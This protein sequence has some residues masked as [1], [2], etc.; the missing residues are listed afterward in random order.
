MVPQFVSSSVY[1]VL[2]GCF[3]WPVWRKLKIRE[4]GRQNIPKRGA[5]IFAAN[6]VKDV[7]S[8]IL[9]GAARRLVHFMAKKTLFDGGKKLSLKFIKILV[10]L[11]GQI[12]VKAGDKLVVKAAFEMA[13]A[14]LKRGGAVGMHVEGT[15][16]LDGKL[17]APKLGFTK[18]AYETRVPVVPVALR[19]DG[20]PEIHFGKPI[21]Y[22]TYQKWSAEQFGYELQKRLAK[23]SGQEMSGEV[24]PIVKKG[25][26]TV[27]QAIFTNKVKPS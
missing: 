16:T 8:V 4:F 18:L 2:Y 9:L 23:L 17:H 15:R 20:D 25:D 7:D 3:K 1:Y 12:P 6:H 19:Y 13:I 27:V 21:P 26:T 10:K 11:T 24:S 22:S 5:V 14:Y